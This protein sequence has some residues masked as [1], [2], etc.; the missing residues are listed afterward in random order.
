MQ[1]LEIFTVNSELTATDG[2]KKLATRS[3][4]R[5]TDGKLLYQAAAGGTT[6]DI[7]QAKRML[8]AI[9]CLWMLMVRVMA[10]M[11]YG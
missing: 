2:H 5:D 11:R 7:T 9:L 4:E 3:G 8:M 1:I 10:V 6:T